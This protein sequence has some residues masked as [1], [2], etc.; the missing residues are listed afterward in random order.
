MRQTYTCCKKMYA[1][2]YIFSSNTIVTKK[3]VM[4]NLKKK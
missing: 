4:E 3:V 2:I 1:Y